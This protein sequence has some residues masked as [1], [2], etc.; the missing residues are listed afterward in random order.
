ME[1]FKKEIDELEKIIEIAITKRIFSKSNMGFSDYQLKEINYLKKEIEIKNRKIKSILS[2][3]FVKNEKDANF[4]K[5][6]NIFSDI[7]KNLFKFEE[8]SFKEVCALLKE[9]KKIIPK[10]LEKKEINLPKLPEEI[11]D[12]VK[13]N[14]DELTIC[15]ENKC[16]RSSLILCGKIIEIA[17]HR[18]YFEL[19]NKDLLEKSPDIGLGTILA[20]MRELGIIFDPGLPQQIH[21]I[22]QLRVFSVHK[23]T[24]IF[25]PSKEQ[26]QATLLYTL[27]I[28]NKLFKKTI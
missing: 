18:K 28:L 11:R 21:L 10:V 22:N 13:A 16:Y 5:I 3:Q 23:K 2:N 19:T 20:K 15:F 25:Q 7:Q 1:N 4:L 14:F 8:R 26:A 6:N 17:L 24:Q 9:I 27:D 12:E